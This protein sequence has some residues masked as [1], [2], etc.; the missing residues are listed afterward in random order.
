MKLDR[1]LPSSSPWFRV[2]NP[3]SDPRA[4]M[5]C[6]PHAGGSADFFR[7]W[8]PGLPEGVELWPVELPG[9]GTRMSEPL[10]DDLT[11]VVTDLACL[12]IHLCDRPLVVFG[13]SMGSLIAFELARRLEAGG[14][15]VALVIASGRQAP[16]LP[17]L[18]PRHRLPR[19][20]L[21]EEL[22]RLDGTDTEIFGYEELL[23]WVL[24]ILRND[25]KLIETHHVAP[26]PPISAPILVL[27]GR[28]DCDAPLERLAPWSDLT[29]GACSFDLFPGGHFYLRECQDAVIARINGALETLGLNRMPIY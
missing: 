4:R 5:L 10:V 14:H 11:A 25:F 19:Q 29:C 24:P 7:G 12:A 13:H 26:A 28:E 18:N 8:A 1:N 3:S 17:N 15:P 16:H 21:I 9:R 27:G 20:G 2:L 23:D 6:I 22:R